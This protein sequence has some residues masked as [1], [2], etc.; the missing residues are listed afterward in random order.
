VMSVCVKIEHACT[1]VKPCHFVAYTEPN[2]NRNVGAALIAADSSSD[3]IELS[4]GEAAQQVVRKVMQ[5]E[6]AGQRGEPGPQQEVLEGATPLVCIVCFVLYQPPADVHEHL[7]AAQGIEE[8]EG[9]IGEHCKC[10]VCGGSVV[11]S[12]R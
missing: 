9:V 8:V 11:M 12:K 5:Q 6:A 7:A 1:A 3:A 4:N 10:Q 2:P